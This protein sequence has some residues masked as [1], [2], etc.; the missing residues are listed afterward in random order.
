MR[1]VIVPLTAMVAVGIPMA[2][3]DRVLAQR[4]GGIVDLELAGSP[5]QAQHLL[6]AWGDTGRAVARRSLLTDQVWLTTYVATLVSTVPWARARH[7]R[8][9]SRLARLD[10]AVV[11]AA[12]GAGACD[13]VENSLLLKV[14]AG[15]T[16]HAPSARLA[17]LT[18]FG[19]VGAVVL[20]LG[21][22]ARPARSAQD[23]HESPPGSTHARS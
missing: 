22:A 2:R 21:L 10:R 8:R 12:V 14:V 1:R 3:W 19:L 20:W 11:L 4:G 18:K 9:G 13:V 7:E 23:L 6:D 15:D 16:A 17:A 5:Q